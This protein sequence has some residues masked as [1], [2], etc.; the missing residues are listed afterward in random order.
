MRNKKI[1]PPKHGVIHEHPILQRAKKEDRGKAARMLADKILLAAKVDFF[2]G[3]PIGKS[4]RK[5][6]EDRFR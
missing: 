6:L 3:K 5:E 2:K 4:L 1:R